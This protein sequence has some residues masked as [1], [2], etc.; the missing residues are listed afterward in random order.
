MHPAPSQDGIRKP[1]QKKNKKKEVY[2]QRKHMPVMRMYNHAQNGSIG[3]QIYPSQSQR[4]ESRF[5]L[6]HTTQTPLQA[7]AALFL[8]HES[9]FHKGTDSLSANLLAP[10]SPAC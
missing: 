9:I 4:S 10:G 2:L 6:S 5:G 7:F 8:S 1:Q 3:N